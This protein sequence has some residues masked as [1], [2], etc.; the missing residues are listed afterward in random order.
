MYEKC[1]NGCLFPYKTDHD[2]INYFLNLKHIIITNEDYYCFI[3]I[4]PQ[5]ICSQNAK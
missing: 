3:I 4:T 1:K 5:G 2:P